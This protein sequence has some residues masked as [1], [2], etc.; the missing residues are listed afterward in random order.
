MSVTMCEPTLSNQPQRG[1]APEACPSCLAKIYPVDAAS[2]PIELSADG[3]TIGRDGRCDLTL[4]DDSVSRRHARLEACGGRYMVVDLDSKNG[5]YINDVRIEQ[6]VLVAGD[7]LRVGNQI[8]KFLCSHDLETHYHE[9]VYQRMTTDGLTGACNKRCLRETL[10]REVARAVRHARPL[11]LAMFDVDHFKRI[12]DAHGHLA[13]DEV[14]QE[15]CR[16]ACTV[17]R[18]DE[19]LARY[20]GEEFVILMSEA[21]GEDGRAVAERL[22]Q[23]VAGRSFITERCRVEVTISVGIAELQIDANDTA[24]RLLARADE[25]LY[26]A[27][28]GGRNRVCG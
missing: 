18:Q 8:F 4:A 28:R 27:K 15:L 13:G 12:N 1:D 3:L 19:L 11:T 26:A 24:T 14:L 25:Q 20:G 10:D 21:T 7:R 6:Q 16:R 22:R 5:T 17:L 2:G 9:A 23:V